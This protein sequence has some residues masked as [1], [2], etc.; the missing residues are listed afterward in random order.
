MD[1]K[2]IKNKNN[3]K[4]KRKPNIQHEFPQQHVNQCD[5]FQQ[6]ES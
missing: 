4:M 5:L 3:T 6:N 1:K 2:K